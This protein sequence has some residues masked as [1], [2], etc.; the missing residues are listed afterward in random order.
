MTTLRE[1]VVLTDRAHAEELGDLL[2]NA[3]VMCVTTEDADAQTPDEMPLFGE[4]GLEPESLAWAR[5]RLRLLADDSFDAVG[6]LALAAAALGIETPRIESDSG[7][8]D[9]DWVKI[10]QAQFQPVHVSERLWIVPSW[11]EPPDPS[12]L[13]IRLDPGV[14]FGTGAHPTT[15]LCLQWLD[16]NCRAGDTVLDYGCGTGILAIAAAKVGAAAVEG[17][18]IDPQ[19]VEAARR[20]AA[21]NG[22]SAAFV[23]P[24]AL[25]QNT[26]R[27]VVANILANPLKSLAPALLSR[28][29]QGGSLVLSGILQAQA[30]GVI[31]AYREADPGV[32]LSVW[33]QQD[34]WACIAGRR[35]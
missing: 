9:E 15:R 12:A 28:V 25:R 34:G 24:E 11:H 7:V 33:G 31:A 19:A 1:I 6:S 5:S 29:A 10:T 14:A 8:P 22:V 3:G 17:T 23:L 4:P 35:D 13:N 32:T 16:K 21:D 30:E 18:D 26:Y 20:N 2:M 27:V